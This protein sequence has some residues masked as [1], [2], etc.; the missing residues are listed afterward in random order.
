MGPVPSLWALKSIKENY[1]KHVK[2]WTARIVEGTRGPGTK[3][4]EPGEAKA[5]G[6]HQGTLEED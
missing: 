6:V 4:R 2:L 5:A 1:L 3:E